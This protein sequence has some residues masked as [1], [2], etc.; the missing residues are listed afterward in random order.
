MNIF[1]KIEDVYVYGPL[2]QND[3]ENIAVPH[4]II[5][6]LDGY[7]VGT[8]T[9]QEQWADKRLLRPEPEEQSSGN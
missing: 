7:Y 1:E 8:A 2:T 3:V 4:H 9:E 6:E 5:K